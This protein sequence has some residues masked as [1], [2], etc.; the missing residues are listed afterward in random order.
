MGNR[1]RLAVI[2]TNVPIVANYALKSTDQ[3]VDLPD[4]CVLA[5]VDI[6]TSVIK[7]KALVIDS[8]DEI[9]K[10]YRNNLSLKGQPGLGDRFMR[11]VHD[12]RWKLQKKNRVTITKTSGTYKEFP[13]HENLSNFDKSDRKFVAV[14]N[15]HPDKP[16]IYQAT[17]SK[18]WGW[19]E[20]LVD[21]G[22]QVI[23]LCPEYI[24]K[25]YLKKMRQ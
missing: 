13:V 23:F 11:W 8:G 20:A 1:S 24:K 6:I 12:N 19:K 22:I 5:C 4:E 18:W 15:V 7:D 2:D 14:A 17:D 3:P 25:K 9:Y 16:P 21:C 10:E